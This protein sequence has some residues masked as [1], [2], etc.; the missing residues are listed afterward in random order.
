M[1]ELQD[2]L[3]LIILYIA[4]AMTMSAMF[5]SQWVVTEAGNDVYSLKRRSGLFQQCVKDVCVDTRQ[6]DFKTVI[7]IV[8]SIICV[9]CAILMTLHYNQEQEGVESAAD[10][11]HLTF[12]ASIVAAI[13]LLLGCTL[14]GLERFGEKSYPGYSFA[15]CVVGA[16]LLPVGGA[17]GYK[18]I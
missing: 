7:I 4:G 18:K 1:A 9:L 2:V 10:T 12:Y 6:N 13:L 3:H 16:L 15:L 14:M 8:G 11:P 5:T 17:C